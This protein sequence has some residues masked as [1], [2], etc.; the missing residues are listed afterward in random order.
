MLRRKLPKDAV[1]KKKKKI[2]ANFQ[3]CRHMSRTVS[4]QADNEPI[5]AL[6]DL[7]MQY[8]GKLQ[9]RLKITRG[10]RSLHE[11]RYKLMWSGG[12]LLAQRRENVVGRV[13]SKYSIY[14]S[15]WSAAIK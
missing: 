1:Q 11:D 10:C 9:N 6:V 4:A 12:S 3:F 2:Y 5:D 15:G 8:L 7:Q 14:I 13:R